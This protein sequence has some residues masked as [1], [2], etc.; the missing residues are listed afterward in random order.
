MYDINSINSLINFYG[1]RRE[2][3]CRFG[4]STSCITNWKSRGIPPGWHGEMF[5]DL[6]KQGKTFDPSLFDLAHHEA[7][8]A[9][10]ELITL[11]E[12]AG[13]DG[14]ARVA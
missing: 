2:I 12:K 11:R 4:V 7:A 5:L 3:Q 6:V 10:N 13:G 1:G 8:E 9:L 14:S